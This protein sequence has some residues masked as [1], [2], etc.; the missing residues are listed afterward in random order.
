[1]TVLQYPLPSGITVLTIMCRFTKL[2]KATFVLKSGYG[3][4]SMFTGALI[5]LAC[6]ISYKQHTKTC[7]CWLDFVNMSQTRVS[8]D[9][10]I[11]TEELPSSDCFAASMFVGAGWHFLVCWLMWETSPSWVVLSMARWTRVFK[12]GSWASQRKHDSKQHS[13]MV[14]TRGNRGSSEWVK[15]WVNVYCWPGHCNDKGLMD[16]SWARPNLG[17]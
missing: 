14:S 15:S 1:M 4:Y 13:S 11:S 17:V 10:G 9:K 6:V 8:W 12:N 16:D 5:C 3:F 7:M 2:F